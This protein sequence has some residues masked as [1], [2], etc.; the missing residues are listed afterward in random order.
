MQ[1]SSNGTRQAFT[2][3][4]RGGLLL[5]VLLAAGCA[6]APVERA[7]DA[8]EAPV[9]DLPWE[10]LQ[11]AGAPLI[12][13]LNDPE[14][15]TLEMLQVFSARLIRP[16]QILNVAHR[17]PDDVLRT[18]R[19]AAP[20]EVVA[21][22]PVA[23]E[24]TRTVSGL[25]VFYAGVLD[26]GSSAQGVD[27]LPPF[28]VQLDYWLAQT[29]SLENLGVIGSASMAPRMAELAAAAS[30]RNLRLEQ[31]TVGSDTELLLA[32]RAMVPRID[33][34]VFLPDE[35]VLSPKVIQQV[36]SHGGHNDVQILVYSPVMFN[37]GASLYLE[38]DPVKVADA[39][40]TLLD[41]PES[42]P[43]VTGMRSRSRLAGRLA[44]SVV[45]VAV[46]TE[47]E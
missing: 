27:A 25:D 40:V 18:L 34:F 28:T 31:R 41:D 6:T 37:L 17:D 19:S 46:R 36:V 8:G 15:R 45:E 35:T 21:I 42:R 47:G 23:Y 13:V 22:G 32:F 16:Y 7:G 30:A 5:L 11:P 9:N 2:R 44:L 43:Q 1:A 4:L 24:L 3:S 12:V 33:G 20:T 39:L 38:P 10:A 29:A 14:L 26:P